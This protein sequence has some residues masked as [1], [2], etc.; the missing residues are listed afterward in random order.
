MKNLTCKNKTQ[1]KKQ[2]ENFLT[3]TNTLTKQQSW[4]LLNSLD[5]TSLKDTSAVK[6]MI[7]SKV[8]NEVD[9]NL[10]RKDYA[11]SLKGKKT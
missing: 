9:V 10:L 6:K 4:A 1:L 2:A 3:R 11:T 7:Q 5:S 8:W